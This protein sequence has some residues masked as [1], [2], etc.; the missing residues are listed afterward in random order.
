MYNKDKGACDRQDGFGVVGDTVTLGSEVFHVTK[1][2]IASGVLVIRG[3]SL[4][5]HLLKPVR[6]VLGCTSIAK[7]PRTLRTES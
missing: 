2:R 4:V 5:L 7:R 3:K 6:L 1:S